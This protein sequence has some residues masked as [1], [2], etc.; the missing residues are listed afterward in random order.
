M[1]SDRNTP[2]E[3][4]V[5][6][7]VYDVLERKLRAAPRPVVISFGEGK[8]A[9]GAGRRDDGQIGLVFYSDNGFDEPQSLGYGPINRDAPR[10]KTS[11]DAIV[12]FSNLESLEVLQTVLN[13]ARG[14]FAETPM[15]KDIA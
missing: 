13:L 8:G 12:T 4:Y 9:I 7:A 6:R 2:D 5:W 14:M 15:P 10:R 3:V 1:T 11:A